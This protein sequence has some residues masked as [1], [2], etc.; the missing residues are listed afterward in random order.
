DHG[1]PRLHQAALPGCTA[2]AAMPG[3]PRHLDVM[4]AAARRR[5]S[6]LRAR[7]LTVCMVTNKQILAQIG[8]L[9]KKLDVIMSQQDATDAAVRALAAAPPAVQPAAATLVTDV[10]AIAAKI[11]AGETVD[12]TALDALVTTAQGVQAAIDTATASVA[13]LAP[14]PAQ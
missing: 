8:I 2:R 1:Q 10:E 11:A 9:N 3:M 14:P 13:A 12:T 7:H 6:R 5:P 4:V